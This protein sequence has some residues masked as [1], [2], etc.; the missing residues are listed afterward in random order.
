MRGTTVAAALFALSL[1]IGL[2]SSAIEPVI[3]WDE[4]IY[5]GLGFNLASDPL[6]Y[7]FYHFADLSYDWPGQA[8]YR[9]PLLPYLLAAAYM[10]R[11]PVTAVVPL[12][13]AAGVVAF[14]LFAERA[15]GPKKGLLA[16]AFLA[17]L[18]LLDYF[19][20]KMLTDALAAAMGAIILLLFWR[21]FEEGD[22][23]FKVATGAAVGLA[24]L[25]R[26][27]YV[28]L[29]GVLLL[30]LI[31]RHRDFR[32]LRD[33]WFWAA[34]AAMFGVLLPWFWY[35]WQAYGT[36][37]GPLIH[38]SFAVSYWGGTQ[39]LTFYAEHLLEAFSAIGVAAVLGVAI[40]LRRKRPVELLLMIWL[41]AALAFAVVIPHK[42][43][44]FLL[45]AAP[46]LAGLA[47]VG[48]TALP[49]HSLAAG[50][51]VLLISAG[52]TT[53][54]MW[55]TMTATHTGANECFLGAMHYLSGVD[56]GATIYNR[57]SPVVYYYTHRESTPTPGSLGEM[58]VRPAYYLWSQTDDRVQVR[59]LESQATKV[60]SCESAEVW[61]LG[62]QSPGPIS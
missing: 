3:W 14:Y 55:Y 6:N 58:N 37:L 19:S 61:A 33:R 15:M 35:G 49:R 27:T 20:G 42:E 10:L 40:S 38:S 51:A 25:A 46:A 21:G 59:G 23:R 30:Y 8:G 2:V 34:G 29:P 48:I 62:S 43:M 4:G 57:D 9:A 7:S 31:M 53:G 36:P 26:A 18:P 44:R 47:A 24:I 12:A 60:W 5:S 17:A 13:V 41:A 22:R 54:Q 39:P 11:F 28:W 16:A 45:T 56:S 52:T 32:F 1:V 50:A